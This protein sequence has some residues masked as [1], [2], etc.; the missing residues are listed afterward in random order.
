LFIYSTALADELLRLME[1]VK[2]DG[3]YRLRLSANGSGIEWVL[4]DGGVEHVLLDEP[5]ADSWKR[6]LLNVLTPFVPEN[7]LL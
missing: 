5:E 7:L 4:M 3:S 6:L 1:Y 2:V